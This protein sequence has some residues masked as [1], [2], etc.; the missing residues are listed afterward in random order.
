[1]TRRDAINR[2]YP[3]AAGL[4]GRAALLLIPP[5]A[6]AAT[7]A[8]FGVVGFRGF[9]VTVIVVWLFALYAELRDR[10]GR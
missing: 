1:M 4:P 3:G 6:I 7:L 10:Y 9:V 5:V 2:R 8:V